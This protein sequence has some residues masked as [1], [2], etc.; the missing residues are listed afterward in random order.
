MPAGHVRVFMQIFGAEGAEAELVEEVLGQDGRLESLLQ[1]AEGLRESGFFE[2]SWADS[3]SADQM[4]RRGEV[5]AAVV[6]PPG[7]VD[8][9][10]RMIKR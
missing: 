9:F 3:L 1:V 5:T 4:V 8:D 10:F 2:V 7:M 6:L